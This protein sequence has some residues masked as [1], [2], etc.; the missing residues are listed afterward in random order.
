MTAWRDGSNILTGLYFLVLILF[1]FSARNKLYKYGKILMI[2]INV[3]YESIKFQNVYYELFI[4][5]KNVL[6]DKLV[7]GINHQ[8]VSCEIQSV[9]HTLDAMV[10]QYRVSHDSTWIQS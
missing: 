3:L 1:T 10:T 4:V 5:L 6:W 8:Q 9:N 7:D 2:D